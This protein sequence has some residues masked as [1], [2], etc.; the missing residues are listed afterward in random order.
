M[1]TAEGDDNFENV[2]V[3]K[4]EPSTHGL[5]TSPLTRRG[6]GPRTKLGKERSKHN[7]FKHG[8]FSKIVV[9]KGES[10]VQFDALLN[11]LCEDFQPVGTFQKGL[12]EILAVTRW[13]QRRALV[14]QLAEI[15][16]GMDSIEWD[17]KERQRVEVDNVTI[18]WN[19]G[20]IRKIANPEVLQRCLHLLTELRR[21]S[22]L[23][24]F[25][26]EKDEE[27]LRVLY[28]YSEN[29][30]CGRALLDSYQRCSEAVD[31]EESPQDDECRKNFLGELAKEIERLERYRDERASIESNRMKLEA[32]RRSVPDSPQLDRLLRYSASLE[33][34]FD[35]TLS[36]L[37]RA[38]RMRQGQPA[39]P[40]INLDVSS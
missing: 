5:P 11:G 39:T 38:Q 6:T 22:E 27:A 7:A 18:D 17:E 29:F 9:L 40:R 4:A 2:E 10:Q 24:D 32:L 16:A 8:I 15:Q 30:N 25:E 26:P 12:V 36:Q 3:S 20:L 28:G 23:K 21:R 35:R 37:E 19:S 13:C 34:T 31:P 33:R 14:A 1:A